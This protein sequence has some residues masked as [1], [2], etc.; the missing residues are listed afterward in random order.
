MEGFGGWVVVLVGY[1]ENGWRV[2]KFH[3]VGLEVANGIVIGL[4]LNDRVWVLV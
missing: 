4:R 2:E 1:G 3:V